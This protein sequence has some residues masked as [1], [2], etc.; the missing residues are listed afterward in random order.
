MTTS[1]FKSR[2]RGEVHTAHQGEAANADNAPALAAEVLGGFL[3]L[4]P[5]ERF[6]RYVPAIDA[7]M[8]ENRRPVALYGKLKDM[9]NTTLDELFRLLTIICFGQL[10]IE[11]VDRSDSLFNHVAQDLAVDMAQCWRPDEAFLS[12]RTTDQLVQLARDSG[13]TEV[14]GDTKGWKKKELVTALVR[15][16]QRTDRT[17][18]IGWLPDAMRFNIT[19]EPEE[20]EDDAEL[21]D[22]DDEA[23]DADADEGNGD[24]MADAA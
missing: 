18:A 8:R 21:D 14:I 6:N 1:S 15:Y 4:T 9:G 24:D 17:G 3:D 22:E 5:R 11:T 12:G 13:A 20:A 2:I 19:E 23:F 10:D 16:F 7:I